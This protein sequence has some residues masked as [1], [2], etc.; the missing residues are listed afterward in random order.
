MSAGTALAWFGWLSFVAAVIGVCAW[1][2]GRPERVW[3]A[4]FDAMPQSE[5]DAGCER[6]LA[7][8]RTETPIRDGLALEYAADDLTDDS[9]REWLR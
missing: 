9:L 3:R 4:R 7:A 5:R 6:L 1:I 8:I 2:D